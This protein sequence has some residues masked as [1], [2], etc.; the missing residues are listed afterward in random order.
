MQK[1][2]LVLSSGGARGM[3]HIGVIEELEAK[4][5]EISAIAGS[6]IGALIGSIY[7]QGKLSE[8]KQW[9]TGLD[10][11]DVFRLMDFTFNQQGIIKGDKVFQKMSNF[12]EN[13]LIEELKIPVAIVA[14]DILNHKEVVFTK[15][16]LF[17]ALRSTIAVPTII[18]PHSYNHQQLFDGG[19]YNPLPVNHVKRVNNEL[20]VVVNLNFPPMKNM[21]KN[22]LTQNYEQGNYFNHIMVKI[23]NMFLSKEE[24]EETLGYFNL[25]SKVIDVMQVRISGLLMDQYKP[26]ILINI[27]RNACGSFEYHRANEMI[28]LGRKEFL[29]GLT[30]F[31]KTE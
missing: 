30:E 14:T 28:E 5:F 7:A 29:K 31:K 21:K 15:G 4:G 25:I 8:Y 23:Q 22:E 2:S 20:L 10:K 26:D 17:E 3:A 13:K 11:Y 1:V 18:T 19:V 16:P 12:I 9:V 27:P 6:S 24:H